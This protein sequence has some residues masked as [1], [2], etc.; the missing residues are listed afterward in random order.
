MEFKVSEKEFNR[1]VTDVSLLESTIKQLRKRGVVTVT[2]GRIKLSQKFLRELQQTI[3]SEQIQSFLAERDKELSTCTPDEVALSAATI[4]TLVR[5]FDGITFEKL[6][7]YLRVLEILMDVKLCHDEP[8]LISF[9]GKDWNKILK[10]F[11]R[12]R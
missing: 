2:R 10:K 5:I 3:Q 9:S 4:T 8:G 11:R 12:S 1:L 7:S 6:F